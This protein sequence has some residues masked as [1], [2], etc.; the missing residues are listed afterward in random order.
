MCGYADE[1]MRKLIIT[2]TSSA[3]LHICTLKYGYFYAQRRV[4]FG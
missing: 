3:H 1:K 2:S 4:V